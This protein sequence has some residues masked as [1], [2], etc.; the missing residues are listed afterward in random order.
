[1]LLDRLLYVVLGDAVRVE[2]TPYIARALFAGSR[3]DHGGRILRYKII[4]HPCQERAI[5]FAY[6]GHLA[7]PSWSWACPLRQAKV[8][9]ATRRTR[10]LGDGDLFPPRLNALTALLL[11]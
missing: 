4:H 8:M 1:M 7:V 11:N 2:L 5:L 6:R 9:R 10:V 3:G